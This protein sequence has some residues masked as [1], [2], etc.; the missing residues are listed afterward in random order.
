MN[1]LL[2]VEKVNSFNQR[3]EK[4]APIDKFLSDF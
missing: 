4:G 2:L 3:K 1:E